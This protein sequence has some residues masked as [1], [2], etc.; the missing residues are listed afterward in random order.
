M[1][2]AMSFCSAG[3]ITIGLPNWLSSS[4]NT[5]TR[6]RR[7]IWNVSASGA[8]IWATGS[9]TERWTPI[10]AKRSKDASTSAEVS[11]LPLWNLIPLRILN[12]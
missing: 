5:G 11:V 8:V 10:F 3:M 2:P 7:T 4:R 1:P 9:R 6:L 12:V